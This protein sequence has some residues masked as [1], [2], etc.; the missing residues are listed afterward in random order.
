MQDNIY[1]DSP[2]HSHSEYSGFYPA[3][4]VV[5]NARK[6]KIRKLNAEN[7]LFNP[8]YE[9]GPLQQQMLLE[10]SRYRRQIMLQRERDKERRRRLSEQ[11]AYST[12]GNIGSTASRE[13]IKSLF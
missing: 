7:V 1:M 8:A 11:Q 6:V 4:K 2:Q 3:Y 13:L 5:E 12:I 10:D 9:L